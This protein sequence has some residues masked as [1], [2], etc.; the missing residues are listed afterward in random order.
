VQV[1][2]ELVAVRPEFCSILS[3]GLCPGRRSSALIAKSEDLPGMK[4]L[5]H[6]SLAEN[7]VFRFG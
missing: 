2:H 1:L 3:L 5:S 4:L 6:E 7:M